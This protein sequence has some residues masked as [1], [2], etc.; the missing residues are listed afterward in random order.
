[1]PQWFNDEFASIDQQCNPFLRF[2]YHTG[3]TKSVRGWVCFSTK[4]SSTLMVESP[5][6]RRSRDDGLSVHAED[7]FL[8]LGKR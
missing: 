6:E 8:F 5:L 4:S 1:M 7:G 3:S 2:Q